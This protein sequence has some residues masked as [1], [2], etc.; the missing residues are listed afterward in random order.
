VDM[1]EPAQRAQRRMTI[2]DPLARLARVDIVFK[3]PPSMTADDDALNV[4]ATVLGG[5]RS[6]RLYEQVV[7]QRQLA[8]NISAFRGE[9]MGPGLFRIIGTAAPGKSIADVEAAIHGEIERVSTA[10]VAD[11]EIR[12]ARA[13]AR[14]SLVAGL[15]SS[16][17]RAIQLSQYAAF[18]DNPGLINTRAARLD[19]VTAADVQR[20]ARQY[21]TIENRTVVTTNP[22]PAAGR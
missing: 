6:S 7:R 8:S 19:A 1:T 5:G 10:S 16:L 13:T 4:L 2:D 20:V 9:S 3:V 21:L 17:Q 12:K 11:W 15:Q 18:Y 22:K 14:R